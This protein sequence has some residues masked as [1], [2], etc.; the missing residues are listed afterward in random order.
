[1]KHKEFDLDKSEEVINKTLEGKQFETL[2]YIPSIEEE[3]SKFTYE[4]GYY[5]NCTA[6]FIDI[7]K[8]TELTKK[9]HSHTVSK[10][11][12]AYIGQVVRI[13]RSMETCKSINIVGDC[14]SAIF[15]SKDKVEGDKKDIIEA[16]QSASMT[17]AMM[18]LL[19]AKFEKRTDKFSKINAGIGIN[20][21]SSLIIKAGEK[22]S[23]IHKLVFLGDCINI[24][25]HLCDN[26]GN[27]YNKIKVSE[28]IYNSCSNF[29]CNYDDNTFQDFL[30]QSNLIDGIQTYDGSFVRIP[31]DDEAERIRYRY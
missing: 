27:E 9:M 17:N 6:I 14:I 18:N 3:D 28:K 22:G 20:Y 12:R 10:F 1:M 23:G 2:D 7:R 25:S 8:S 30:E 26:I 4:N 19:N 15:S 16:L 11:Y 31:I 13:L 29:K 24:A 21:G 5:V